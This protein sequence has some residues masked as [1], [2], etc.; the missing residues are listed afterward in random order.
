MAGAF[1]QLK[2]RKQR[3][4]LNEEEIPGTSGIRALLVCSQGSGFDNFQ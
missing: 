1:A 2:N 3:L 4:L